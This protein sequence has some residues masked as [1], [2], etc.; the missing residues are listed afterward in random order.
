MRTA[1]LA[2]VAL[3]AFSPLR[4]AGMVYEDR[5]WIAATAQPATTWL[6]MRPLMHVSWWFQSRYTPSPQAFHALNLALH[7]TL[8]LLVALLAWRLSAGAL[9]VWLAGALTLLH[10]MTVESV[11]YLSARTELFAAIGVVGAC[12]LSVHAR[13]W[14]WLLVYAALAFGMAG[15]ETAAIGFLLI[16]LTRWA[17]GRDWYPSLVL[18]S[19]ALAWGISLKGGWSEVI[20]LGEV[21]S[22]MHTDWLSWLLIQ[23]TATVRLIS[24]SLIPFFGGFTVDYD[25]DLIPHTLRL[26]ALLTLTAIPVLAWKVRHTRPLLAFGL[27]WML[28]AVAPRLIVQTPRSYLNEHQFLVAFLGLAIA[29]A[30]LTQKAT[31]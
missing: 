1:A 3:A 30:S 25:Y 14:R 20:A 27:A 19:F 26:A 16:P 10:P 8:A 5:T 2:L 15:K 6:P 4:S 12:A 11:A 24:L 7:V 29:G 21:G 28:I 9:S 18:G 31:T 17:V 23:S 13:G 22:W